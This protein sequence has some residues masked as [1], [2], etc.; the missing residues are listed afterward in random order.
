MPTQTKTGENASPTK[1]RACNNVQKDCTAANA[2]PC[3]RLS[4]SNVS[5]KKKKTD[6]NNKTPM[7]L[8]TKNTACQLIHFKI[9]PPK[10]GDKIGAAP[11]TIAS[12]AMNFVNSFPLYISLAAARAITIPAAPVN[13]CRKRKIINIQTEELM[14]HK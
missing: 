3:N 12:K 14:P 10:T 1:G 13:P 6:K 5:G 7:L 2:S 8:K 4:C 9:K 11:M